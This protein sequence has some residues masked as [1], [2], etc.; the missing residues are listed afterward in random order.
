MRFKYQARTKE[1]LIQIGTIKAPTKEKAISFLQSQGFYITYLEEDVSSFKSLHSRL[2]RS[3]ITR[4]DIMSFS[5]Q[6]A[7]LVDAGISLVEALRTVGL[8]TEKKTFREIIL[9]IAE[10]VESGVY[11]S[12]ALSKFPTIFTQ[13]YVNMVKSGETSG[14]LSETLNYLATHLEK[15]YMLIEKI[16]GALMYPM[17]IFTMLV[18]VLVFMVIYVFPQIKETFEPL[19]IKFPAI[20]TFLFN[21]GIFLLKWWWVIIVLL[22]F[23]VIVIWRY[24]QTK[25]GKELIN[26]ILPKLPIFGSL[27]TKIY[28]ARLSDN[29]ATLIYAGL[30][31]TQ[32]LEITGNI[33]NRT[34]LGTIIYEVKNKV[35]A[36]ENLSSAFGRYVPPVPQLL[37]Q[38]IKVGEKTGRLEESLQSVAEFY[39]K[40]TEYTIE[41]LTRLI[42]PF[43]ILIVGITVALL[44]LSVFLPI[45]SNIG[46]FGF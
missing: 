26:N 19:G 35:R 15:E 4:K 24:F 14:R 38:M 13:F 40:E 41:A 43:L 44:M 46:R 45:Y 27:F 25:E 11:F 36:G 3:R 39:R 30:P 12:D 32:A 16:K 17:F 1:G 34:F 2:L 22:I 28:T 7:L 10:E 29:L 20:T 31:L 23:T 9:Q 37:V 21:V 8:Q 6:L 18:A 33:L 42:E 5:R